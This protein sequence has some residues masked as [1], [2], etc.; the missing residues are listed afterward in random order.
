LLTAHNFLFYDI[1]NPY[2]LSEV[3]FRTP[4]EVFYERVVALQT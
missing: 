3:G 2:L 1:E 4:K